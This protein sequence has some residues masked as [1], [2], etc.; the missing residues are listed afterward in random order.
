VLAWADR[1]GAVLFYS[2]GDPGYNT[3][4]PSDNLAGSGWQFQGQFRNTTSD[5]YLG[6]PISAHHFITARHISEYPSAGE[7]FYYNGTTNVTVGE[8]PIA[9]CDLTV[10]EIDG[11]FSTYAPIY[12]QPIQGYEPV[13]VFGRGTQR[14]AAVVVNGETKGWKWGTKDFVMRWGENAVEGFGT[15]RGIYGSAEPVLLMNFDSTA[16]VNE[17]MLSD[18]DSGGAVFI[19]DASDGVWKLAGINSYVVPYTFSTNSSFS[20]TFSAAIFDFS[21]ASSDSEKL[22]YATNSW[23][24]EEFNPELF[25]ASSRSSHVPSH[26]EAIKSILGDSFDADADGLPDWWETQYGVDATSM[27]RD[28]HLDSDGFTNYEEWLA[29]TV[30]TNGASFREITDYSTATNLTFSSSSSRKYQVQ[31]HTDLL[32]TNMAW[33]TEVDWFEG[34]NSQTVQSVST[35]TSNR[36]YRVRAKPR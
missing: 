18:K 16:G 3:N 1:A 2:T 33:Q 6:T 13:V 24:D 32:D 30:P 9:G 15:M 21:F 5:K 8:F 36:F 35:S 25:P 20:P 4:A 26:L 34:S 17:C 27:E 12:T 22:Y 19:Q 28:G 31:Y 14:G 7:P 11:T 10:W 23:V 29:D